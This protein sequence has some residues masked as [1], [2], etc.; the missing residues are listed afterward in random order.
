VQSYDVSIN[1]ITS[2]NFFKKRCLKSCVIPQAS[3]LFTLCWQYKELVY[4][5]KHLF[6]FFI[7]DFFIPFATTKWNNECLGTIERGSKEEGRKIRKTNRR[8]R[9]GGKRNIEGERKRF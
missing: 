4:L 5:L 2:V 9:G 3:P 6:I 8:E 7:L 1:L